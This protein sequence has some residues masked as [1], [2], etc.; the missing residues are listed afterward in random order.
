[1]GNLGGKLTSVTVMFQMTKIE[2][3][4][5]LKSTDTQRIT[6]FITHRDTP[7]PMDANL[8]Y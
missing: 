6:L 7:I 5:T 1:M 4:T 8:H 2:E 3:N